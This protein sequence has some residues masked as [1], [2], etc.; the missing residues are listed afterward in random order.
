MLKEAREGGLI[1][2]PRWFE[3]STFDIIGDLCFGGS[4]RCLEID[5]NRIQIS[6]FQSA[7]KAFAQIVVSRSRIG[8][9]VELY[10]PL[11]QQ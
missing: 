1:D 2:I 6:I 4:F 3:Y 10:Y 11:N 7:M 9:L 8:K 5:E